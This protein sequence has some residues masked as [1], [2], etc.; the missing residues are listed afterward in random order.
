MSWCFAQPERFTVRCGRSA[1]PRPH[2]RLAA[3]RFF[4]YRAR[5]PAATVPRRFRAFAE[6]WSHRVP[7]RRRTQACW[8]ILRTRASPP[9]FDRPPESREVCSSRS[10]PAPGSEAA[11]GPELATDVCQ[12]EARDSESGRAALLAVGPSWC[13]AVD[14]ARR[15]RSAKPPR[16]AARGVSIR[17]SLVTGRAVYWSPDLRHPARVDRVMSVL[18]VYRGVSV[19]RALGRF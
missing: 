12:S 10:F 18:G 11:S 13:R 16:G 19:A 14:F 4:H 1:F 2:G 7:L 8:G 9:L 6:A 5:R 15:L 17:Y 3:I